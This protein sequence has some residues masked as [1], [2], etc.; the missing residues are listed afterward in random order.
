MPKLECFFLKKNLIWVGV[1]CHPSKKNGK[2]LRQHGCLHEK[3]CLK[4]PVSQI[5]ALDHEVSAS[6]TKCCIFST[7][8]FRKAWPWQTF[9][10]SEGNK[11]RSRHWI[12]WN[13][14]TQW[15]KR[16]PSYLGN[17]DMPILYIDRFFF[18]NYGRLQSF[19]KNRLPKLRP[20][21]HN[22]FLKDVLDRGG[23]TIFDQAHC[24]WSLII[25]LFVWPP[26]PHA[27]KLWSLNQTRPKMQQLQLQNANKTYQESYN[28]PVLGGSSRWM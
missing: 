21:K 16:P 8:P 17:P 23:L 1:C 19:W 9:R 14:T 27:L 20:E 13:R 24:L 25:V 3:K 12:F 4:P 11:R 7:G 18:W 5:F 22:D 6:I 2:Y 10:K 15:I 28:T 26:F